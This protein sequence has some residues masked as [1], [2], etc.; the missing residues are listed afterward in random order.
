MHGARQAKRDGAS[1][2]TSFL[3][4]GVPMKRLILLAGAVFVTRR[5]YALWVSLQSRSTARERAKELQRWEG[6][7][8]NPSLDNS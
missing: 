3:N 7:G 5:L 4:W 8:G 2:T 1:P 6:E